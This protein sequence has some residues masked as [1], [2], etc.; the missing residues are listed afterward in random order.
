MT[1]RQKDKIGKLKDNIQ[2]S[3]LHKLTNSVKIFV[4]FPL[5]M[6][7]ISNM[8]IGAMWPEF[9]LPIYVHSS[10]MGI[11]QNKMK[12]NVLILLDLISNTKETYLQHIKTLSAVVYLEISREKIIFVVFVC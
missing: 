7:F 6:Y 4:S 11:S 9:Q 3:L 8:N 1:M 10:S 2:F 12:Q 5:H